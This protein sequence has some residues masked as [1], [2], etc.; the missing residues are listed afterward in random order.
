MKTVLKIMK[1][2]AGRVFK[3]KVGR[4][5]EKNSIFLKDSFIVPIYIS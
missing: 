3:E 1:W 4:G 5:P 2:R